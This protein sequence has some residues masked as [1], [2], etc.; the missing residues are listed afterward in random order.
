M[1]HALY[2]QADTNQDGVVDE[3]E[4]RALF[5]RYKIPISDGQMQELIELVDINCDGVYDFDE[6][7]GTL[8]TMIK[9]A[10]SA[11]EQPE[12]EVPIAMEEQ[13]QH[14]AAIHHHHNLD[15]GYPSSPLHEDNL[16]PPP[17]HPPPH[18]FE[19][20]DVVVV[21][22]EG[23]YYGAQASVTDA[24]SAPGQLRVVMLNGASMGQ[25][26]W[27]EAHELRAKVARHGGR[28]AWG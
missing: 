21:V 4:L 28:A 20:G 6:I 1:A 3:N 15:G 11:A 24:Y 18:H 13:P 8:I 23:E 19:D 2:H 22:G 10:L 27:F 25:T 26:I 7:S 5:R 16:P 9:Q 14:L 17:A 12:R